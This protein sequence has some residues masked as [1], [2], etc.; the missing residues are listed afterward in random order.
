[1]AGTG[2][3]LTPLTKGVSANKKT[4]AGVMLDP[5]AAGW[6]QASLAGAW[7]LNRH[8][9]TGLAVYRIHR[10]HHRRITSDGLD[11]IGGIESVRD[12]NGSSAPP[13]V[14]TDALH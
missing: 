5:P 1:M 13:N 4:A 6:N 7:L 9:Y 8:S 10:D 14:F 12:P 3:L 11:G 2:L